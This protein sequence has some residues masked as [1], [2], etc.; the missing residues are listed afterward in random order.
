M[1]GKFSGCQALIKKI[2]PLAMYVYCGAHVTYSSRRFK[3]H[4]NFKFNK[5]LLRLCPRV[6]RPSQKLWEIQTPLFE[7]R[8]Q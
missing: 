5:E 1:A 3:S 4:S 7:H 2:Q 6:R 8:S